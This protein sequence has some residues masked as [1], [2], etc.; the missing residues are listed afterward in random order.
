MTLVE[1][2]AAEDACARDE[3]ITAEAAIEADAAFRRGFDKCRA[4]MTAE[5]TLLMLEASLTGMGRLAFLV[6]SR[7]GRIATMGELEEPWLPHSRLESC[8]SEFPS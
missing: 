1:R 4:L 6:E 2:L 8:A 7:L 3:A 5:I